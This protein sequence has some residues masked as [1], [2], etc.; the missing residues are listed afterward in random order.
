MQHWNSYWSRTKSLN[1][2]AEGEHSQGYKGIVASFWQTIFKSLP[3]S[4]TILDLATGNGGL[5]VLAQQFNASFDVYASDAANIAPLS[6]HA[7]SDSNYK[8]LEKIHFYGNMPSE[9][10][11]F[12]NV[13]FDSVI[14]QF[15]F[16]YAEPAAA[17]LAIN[18]ALKPNGEF[19]ALV[20]HQD[21]FISTDCKIG[22][23]VL[24]DLSKDN[25]L[26]L[27]LQDFADFCQ[28][29]TNK[30]EP[31][32]EQ[33]VQFKQKNVD[34]LQQ[35]K[36]QQSKCN[37]E[38]ELD[39]FNLLVKELL[40]AIID[41]PQTDSKR[42]EELRDNLYSFQLRLQDQQAASWSN[43]DVEYIKTLLQDN[44]SS[45]EFD[46]MKIDAGIFCWVIKAR[47]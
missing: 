45:Y 12:E 24:K 22:L 4:T 25:G 41:W 1:S 3:E 18:K 11:A 7:P 9:T 26:L 37:S 31:T 43:S 42:V 8:H 38:D 21:S 32:A 2:F 20:H 17:L 27:Q 14:S 28:S 36:Y 13:Q 35:V 19:I 44:W 5:A 29:I 46:V 34:L 39:W 23:K 30:V 16:E 10:L 6:Q 47:K 40:P 33:Q 15:G